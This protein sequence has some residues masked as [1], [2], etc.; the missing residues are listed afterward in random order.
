MQR[1]LP[2]PA[3]TVS[4]AEVASVIAR[5][6]DLATGQPLDHIVRSCAIASLLAERLELTADERAATYWV[7]LLM[8]SGCSAVS[9]EMSKLFGDDIDLRG[10]G[11]ALGP[12]TTEQA[13][14]L[15]GR[16]GGGSRG[17]TRVRLELV[18]KRLRPFLDAILAHCSINARLAEALGLG[19][20]VKDALTKS[21]AQWNGKGIP[22][23]IGGTEIPM[24]VRV[25]ALADLV[26]VAF[27]QHG[28]RP[29][30]R[31]RHR[32]RSGSP[33]RASRVA[34]LLERTQR[35]CLRREPSRCS[36]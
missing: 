26:E 14:Y 29:A 15:F 30:V 36:G 19:G 13:R 22:E 11:Y 1:E 2:A 17:K 23:G 8:I 9:F 6:A 20:D 27:R 7:S 10:S 34:E 28:V 18:G 25:S 21:F 5:A 16:A 33:R 32:V 24:P 31:S 4:L 12:S 35:T 3:T